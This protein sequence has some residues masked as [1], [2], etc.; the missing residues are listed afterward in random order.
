VFAAVCK[1][2][3]YW[4]GDLYALFSDKSGDY[5]AYLPDASGKSRLMRGT[6]G[7]HFTAAGGDLAAREVIRILDEHYLVEPSS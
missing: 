3:G 6:D 4:Y 1:E 7:I 2:D 5:S